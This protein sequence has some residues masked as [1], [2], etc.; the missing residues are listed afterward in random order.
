M[1]DDSAFGDLLTPEMLARAERDAEIVGRLFAH[2]LAH[3]S[4]GPEAKETTLALLAEYLHHQHQQG[5]RDSANMVRKLAAAMTGDRHFVL[6]RA[7]DMLT[8]LA[9]KNEE[10]H[11]TFGSA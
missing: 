7:S 8:Q 6:K 10:D 9:D 3:H 4:G 2:I 1:A 11:K 5:I